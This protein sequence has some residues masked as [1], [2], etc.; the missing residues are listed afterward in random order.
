[1]VP[2]RHPEVGP[3]VWELQGTLTLVFYCMMEQGK[4]QCNS[5]NCAKSW[6][7]NS[8]YMPVNFL[9]L[10]NSVAHGTRV[11][12]MELEIVFRVSR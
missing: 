9:H 8:R 10:R 4:L 12:I 2:G 11:V 5:Q 7:L 1:M 3:S 6:A